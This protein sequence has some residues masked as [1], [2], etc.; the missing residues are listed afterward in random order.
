MIRPPRSVRIATPDDA[1]ALYWHLLSGLAADNPMECTVSPKKISEWVKKC[2][3]GDGAIA[4]I[5]DGKT[6]IAGSVGICSGEHVFSTDCILEQIWLFVT[7][8]TRRSGRHAIELF[9]FCLWH[10]GDMSRRL[11]YSIPLQMSVLS[12]KRLPAKLRLWSRYGE[13]IGGIFAGGV[14]EQQDDIH[15][16]QPEDA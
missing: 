4:G 1:P 8:G 6:G 15:F 12:R 13:M 10:K 7:P 2:C 3:H 5:I 11:G 14:N 16:D 9:R